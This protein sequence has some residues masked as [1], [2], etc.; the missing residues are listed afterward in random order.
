M[1]NETPTAEPFDAFEQ[2]VVATLTAEAETVVEPADGLE[3]VRARVAHRRRVRRATWLA[4]A[5]ALVLVVGTV[6]VL[7]RSSSTDSAPYV[8]DRPMVRTPAQPLWLGPPDPDDVSMPMMAA[9]LSLSWSHIVFDPAKGPAQ[10]W[11]LDVGVAR[12]PLDDGF[13]S[14]TET[15]INGSTAL[16][17]ERGGHATV[18]W[19]LADGW[20]A[21]V[22]G[23]GA[24]PEPGDA[25]FDDALSAVRSMA[26]SLEAK[27]RGYWLPIIDRSL[28]NGDPESTDGYRLGLHGGTGRSYVTSVDGVQA[29]STLVVPDQPTNAYQLRV[30]KILADGP[31]AIPGDETVVRGRPGKY[32][33]YTDQMGRARRLLSW[34]EGPYEYRLLLGPGV[35][36]GDTLRLAERL[37][38]LGD[39]EWAAAVFPEQIPTDLGLDDGT[40]IAFPQVV[41]QVP[42]ELTE[43][44]SGS[45]GPSVATTVSGSGP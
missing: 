28:R 45:N 21:S 12:G 27:D 15:T 11:F 25:D 7:L 29:Y 31:P 26:E 40:G 6:G 10:A 36:L 23:N 4:A 14:W 33:E 9:G 39:D 24:D 30:S 18:R 38:P 34:S 22:A 35:A 43:G 13:G 16:I 5:A 20:V 8:D 1:T 17:G 42:G 3:L 2:R 44:A 32:S 37:T 19:E 41:Y